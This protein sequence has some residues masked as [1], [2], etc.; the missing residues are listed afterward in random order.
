MRE[1]GLTRVHIGFESGCDEVLAVMTKG[2][3]KAL[4]VGA[5]TQGQGRGSGALRLLHDGLGGGRS[6]VS[7]RSRPPTS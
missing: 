4:H 7:T 3:T 6:G 1:A 2:A 5:G